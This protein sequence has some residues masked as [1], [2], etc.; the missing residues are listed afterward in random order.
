MSL[1]YDNTTVAVAEICGDGKRE[2]AK[3]FT[4]LVNHDSFADR[5]GRPDNDKAEGA[6]STGS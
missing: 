1:L 2:R 4:E 3:T 5:L 6:S